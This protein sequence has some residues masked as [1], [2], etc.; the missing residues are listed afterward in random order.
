MSIININEL[1]SYT[2]EINELHDETIHFIEC[3]KCK[4]IYIQWRAQDGRTKVGEDIDLVCLNCKTG[5]CPGCI[6]DNIQACWNCGIM[7]CYVCK[8]I[9]LN[10]K[11]FD[12]EEDKNHKR[13]QKCQI[14]V[15]CNPDMIIRIC[16]SCQKDQNKDE[17]INIEI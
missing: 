10:N 7:N 13:C 16:D 14:I 17:N 8:D 5:W 4:K 2:K 3:Y 6:K 15:T 9:P 12:L 11:Y 1:L